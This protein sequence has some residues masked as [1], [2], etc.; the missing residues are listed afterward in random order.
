METEHIIDEVSFK[1]LIEL[2]GKPFVIE[3]VDAFLI[4]APKV[5]G[6]ARAGLATGDLEPVIRM[7]HSLHSNGR[8]MGVIRMKDLG[9]RI[10]K[11]GREKQGSE[12]P[13]LV[14]EMELAF[15]QAKSCLEAKKAGL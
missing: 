8:T 13:S 1:A 9:A 2:G 4:F 5:I 15:I 10:E 7:G 12:L 11:A 6:E 3:M 14:D